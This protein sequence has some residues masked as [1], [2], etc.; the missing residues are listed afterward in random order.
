MR[1]TRSEYFISDMPSI[2]DIERTSRKVRVVPKHDIRPIWKVPLGILFSEAVVL[3]APAP[4]CPGLA[5]KRVIENTRRNES[6]EPWPRM[7]SPLSPGYLPLH[8]P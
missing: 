7:A 5:Q 8:R 3:F 4:T 2:T 6:D 1:N